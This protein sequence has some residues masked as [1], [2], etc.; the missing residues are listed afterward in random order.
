MSPRY[1]CAMIE[2]RCRSR[3]IIYLVVERLSVLYVEMP[4][5]VWNADEK[6]NENLI[7]VLIHVWEFYRL[8]SA[9]RKYK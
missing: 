8:D 5:N 4:L 1:D 9:G 7:D 3:Y 2:L 6:S